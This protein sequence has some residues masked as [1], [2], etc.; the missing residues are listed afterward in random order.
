MQLLY[1]ETDVVVQLDNEFRL[2][3]AVLDTPWEST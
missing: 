1:W 3:G 2:H